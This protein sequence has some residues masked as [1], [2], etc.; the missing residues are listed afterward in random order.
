MA[1]S[2]D[3]NQILSIDTNFGSVHDFKMFKGSRIWSY[4]VI[5]NATSKEFDLGF[6]GVTK[7]IPDAKIPHK[8]P[9]KSKSNPKPELTKQE[10]RENRELSSTRV[11]IEN[12]NREIKIFRI[13]KEVRR[14]KQKKHNLFWNLIAGIVNFKKRN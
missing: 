13:C 12:I 6:L 7:Y 9:K 4:Q 1:Y 11:K 8:K 2:T 10:K 5:Q 14:H 3:L